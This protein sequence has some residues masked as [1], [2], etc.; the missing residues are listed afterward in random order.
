[1]SDLPTNDETNKTPFPKPGP[2]VEPEIDTRIFDSEGFDENGRDINGQA[3]YGADSIKVLKGLDGVRKRPGMYLQGGTGIDG[4][5]QLL[6][7][8][9]DNA[10]DEG[11]AGYADTVTVIIR[12]DESVRVFKRRIRANFETFLR[13]THRYWFH[14]VSEQSHVK[15]LQSATTEI[16]KTRVGGIQV[17]LY[18]IEG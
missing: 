3:S 11:Q 6:S 9:I 17:G 14:E 7:E 12:N 1:M 18:G 15:A 8:I 16:L 5:H 2:I 10:I 13:F 4:F